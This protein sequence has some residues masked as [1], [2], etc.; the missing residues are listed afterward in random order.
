MPDF[1]FEKRISF[2][3]IPILMAIASIT[4]GTVVL[5]GWFW[6][7][8]FLTSIASNFSS[9]TPLSALAFLFS[10]ITLLL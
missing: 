8:T 6:E 4:T 10:G 3:S 7:L 1:H 9:M 2:R 5:C